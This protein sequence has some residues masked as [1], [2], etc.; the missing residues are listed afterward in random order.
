[1][2]KHLST[3]LLIFFCTSAVAAAPQIQLA[4]LYSEEINLDEFLVSEKLDGVRGYFDGEKFISRQGNIIKAPKWFTKNFPKQVLDGELWIGRGK[5]ELVAKI[6]RQETPD[7]KA[8]QDVRF[9]IFDLPKSSEIFS[10]RYEIMQSLV[11][12]ADSKYLQVINQFEIKDHEALAS[13]LKSTVKNGGEGLMLHRKNSLYK[14]ERNDDL[15][16]LKTFED[17]EGKVIAHIAGKGKFAGKMGALLI[18]IENSDQQKIRFKIGSGFS[19]EQRKNPP[20]IGSQITYKFF[21]KTKNGTPR[22]ASF[23]RERNE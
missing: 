21:G 5:F 10:K 22:F 18:E 23:L 2:S 7:E 11:A 1:M 13:L 15:L 3:I 12:E 19:V 8:W 16:K 4:N 14:A 6:I 20:A 9:M 17:A